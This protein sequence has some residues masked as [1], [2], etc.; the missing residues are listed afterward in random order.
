M[1]EQNV[2]MRAL[3]KSYYDGYFKPSSGSCAACQDNTVKARPLRE[4]FLQL[5][6]DKKAKTQ[7]QKMKDQMKELK[8]DKE[9]LEDCLKQREL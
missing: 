2:E 8:Q 1:E 3:L 6:T 9:R 7:V 4:K 5:L